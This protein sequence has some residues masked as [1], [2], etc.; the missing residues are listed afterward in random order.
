MP[1]EQ[2][3]VVNQS[4]GGKGGGITSL[5]RAD[6]LTP[7]SAPSFCVKRHMNNLAIDLLLLALPSLVAFAGDSA[8]V[9]AQVVREIRARLPAGWNCTVYQSKDLEKVPHGLG[10]PEFQVVAA[11]TNFSFVKS[12]V[13]RSTK[14][15][16]VVPLYFYRLSEKA[17][18]MKIIE[19]ESVYSWSI[20]IY[21]GET[22]EFVVVT[23]P[24]FVNGGVFT[25]EA[26][27][28]LH[29]MWAVLR[30]LIPN[31]EKTGVDEMAADN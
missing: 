12:D 7:P 30:E 27:H 11:N 6:T 5:S 10:K 13:P 23:S 31:K 3:E 15:Y 24:A 17:E 2:C 19:K 22:D 21:F 26:R 14:Q 25:P 16:P 18:L 28:A 29:P 20:P 4:A 8:N 1:S 9:E